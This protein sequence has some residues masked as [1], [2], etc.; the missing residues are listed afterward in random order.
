MH[1]HALETRAQRW[2][3]PD[4]PLDRLERHG[5][6]APFCSLAHGVHLD[7]TEL[8]RLA[9]AQVAVVSCPSSNHAVSD[10][11]GDVLGWRDAGVPV[12]MGLDSTGAVHPADA[13]AELRALQ[14]AAAARGR[15]L[16]ARDALD[17][18]TRGGAVAGGG[19]G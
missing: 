7:P 11:V 15:T 13:F 2:W 3:G 18:A 4:T 1:T 12:A 10:G 6:L 19:G 5:L 14:R 16:T 17:V 8:A 9:Q